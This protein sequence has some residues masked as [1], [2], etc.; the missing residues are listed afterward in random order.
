MTSPPSNKGHIPEKT[1]VVTA[2]GTMISESNTTINEKALIR[3]IDSRLLPAVTLLYLCSFLDRSNGPL[4]H[5]FS[6]EY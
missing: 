6:A 3:K 1:G 4:M 2:S 5:L